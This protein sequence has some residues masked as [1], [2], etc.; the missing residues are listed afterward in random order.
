MNFGT[1][2]DLYAA[3]GYGGANAQK[4]VVRI[5]E[6]MIRQ[7]KLEKEAAQRQYF[8]DA[9]KS[10]GETIFPNGAKPEPPKPQRS[11][12]GIIVEGLDN[13]L[14]KFSKCCSPVPGDPVVGFITRGYGV[15]VHRA[16]C[17]NAHPDK[18]KPEEAGRWINVR[19]VESEQDGYRTGLEISG[20]DRDGLALDITMAL[21]TLKV[22]V[23]TLAARSQP[24]GYAVVH[25]E[26]IVKNVEEL[27]AV[28]NK[29][30]QIQ[31]VFL[32]Q[33]AKG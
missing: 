5:K 9:I 33:R 17:P 31:G 3:I 24:D 25:L 14:V 18:R 11:A 20:K 12:S 2:D 8:A 10:G 6:E 1:L 30:G 4:V 32:V 23:T 27:T 22:K 7:D 28:I 26:V 15:S 21:S 19:W 29:L 16:D 13:C